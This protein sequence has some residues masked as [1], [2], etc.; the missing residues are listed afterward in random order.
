MSRG[1]SESAAQHRF[2]WLWAG[3]MILPLVSAA[4]A[5]PAAA[6]VAAAGEAATGADS[7]RYMTPTECP[8]FAKP[9]FISRPLAKAFPGMAYSMRPAIKGGEYPYAFA[10]AKRPA[11]MTIDARRGEIAWTPPAAEG[12]HDVEITVKDA[13]GRSATQGFSLTVSRAGFYFVSPTGDDAADGSVDRPWRTV[14]RAASPPEGFSYPAGSAAVLRGGEYK[15]AAP[16]SP[17][18]SNANV[19]RID[20]RSPQYWLAWPGEKPVIDLGWSAE[21]QKAAHDEQRAAGRLLGSDKVPSTQGYGHRIAFVADGG[22]L[23]M[24]G[25]EIRNACYYMLVMWDGR[26][27]IHLR[28]MD[29]RRHFRGCRWVGY[30]FAHINHFSYP[31]S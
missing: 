15:V 6:G 19:L 11:G 17:G 23:Y 20:A 1:P 12:V 10:L 5:V 7:P 22:Y 3:Q 24:D 2:P 9:Q 30:L 13:A 21:K 31:I 25:L 27:T 4:T 16:A 8:G 29:L 28:R 18:R 26:K 14:M